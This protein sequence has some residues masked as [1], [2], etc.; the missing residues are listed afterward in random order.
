MWN[1]EVKIAGVISIACVSQFGLLQ[2]NLSRVFL[3]KIAN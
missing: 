3:Y 1:L 2:Q